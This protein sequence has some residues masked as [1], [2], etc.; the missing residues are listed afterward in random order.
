MKISILTI[1]LILISGFV[2]K[3]QIRDEIIL[4]VNEY[5][6]SLS[7]CVD[8][9]E[10]ISRDFDSPQD[11]AC[12]IYLWIANNIGYDTKAFKSKKKPKA[13]SYRTHK[14]K[15][16]REEKY[17]NKTVQ[18]VF[19]KRKAICDGYSRLFKKLCDLNNI[20]CVMISG[21]AKT[22]YYEIGNS[23]GEK[24]TWNAVKINDKWQLVD[25]TWGAGYVDLDAGTFIHSLNTTY[26]FTEPELFFL[27]HYPFNNDWLFI[28]RTKQD[29]ANLPLYYSA[30]FNSEIK[31]YS[32]E[33]GVIQKDNNGK[34]QIDLD[35]NT[36]NHSFSY[37]FKDQQYSTR[38]EAE[39][40]DHIMTLNIPLDGRKS[41]YLTIFYNHKAIVVY[42]LNIN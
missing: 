21:A 37:C 38:I 18:K 25:V 19:H 12:A 10:K 8:L 26:L 5:P 22:R 4:A 23:G 17:N 36:D 9:A 29:F 13:Y 16:K 41:G 11:R 7:N 31:I 24:H 2:L 15:I 1:L 39:K 35:C 40:N 42:K 34:I 32:P 6:E 28:Q 27:N 20:E 30:F 3:G 14:Q 33:N